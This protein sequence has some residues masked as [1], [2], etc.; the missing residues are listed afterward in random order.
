[1]TAN[2]NVSAIGYLFHN[3]DEQLPAIIPPI[4]KQEECTSFVAHVDKSKMEIRKSLDEEQ[5]LFDGLMQQ[6][7]G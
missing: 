7:F 5:V 6:Y 3:K 4:E 2:V 1:M